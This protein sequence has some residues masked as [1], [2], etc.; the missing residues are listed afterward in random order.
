MAVRIKKLTVADVEYVAFRLAK[1][2]MEWDEPI[3][4]FATRYPAKLEGCINAPFQTYDKKSL[5]KGII[6]KGSALFYYMIKD[7]P[8]QNGNKRIAI[9]SLMYLLFSNGYWLTTS[10]DAIYDF[11]KEI[12]GSDPAQREETMRKIENFIKKSLVRQLPNI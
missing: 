7:H 5:Y 12:A 4:E 11:A 2:M 10:N 3:P 1:E 6:C 8:F 9:T